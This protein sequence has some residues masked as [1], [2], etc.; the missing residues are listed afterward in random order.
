MSSPQ[1][2]P[3]VH[4][5]ALT[6]R[7]LGQAFM[8]ELARLEK[9]IHE[10]GQPERV[11]RHMR[12]VDPGRSIDATDDDLNAEVRRAVLAQQPPPTAEEERDFSV[13]LPA[14]TPAQM[15]QLRKEFLADLAG[16]SPPPPEPSPAEKAK[17]ARGKKL[18]QD[19]IR[20]N[21]DGGEHG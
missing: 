3:E 7:A 8:D 20:S 2:P 9:H 14:L 12:V 16:K 10:M 5:S 13:E 17:Q 15:D 1:L 18:V 6:L 11:V 4:A 21:T 19:F